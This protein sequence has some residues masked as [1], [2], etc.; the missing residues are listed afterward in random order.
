MVEGVGVGGG[1]VGLVLGEVVLVAVAEARR[2]L[3]DGVLDVVEAVTAEWERRYRTFL[4]LR[5][6]G[7]FEKE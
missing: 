4:R 7:C 5:K 1:G 2:P 6:R 3:T